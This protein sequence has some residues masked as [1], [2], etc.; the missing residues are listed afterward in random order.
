MGT[1][2]ILRKFL[3]F[4][5]RIWRDKLVFISMLCPLPEHP[6][7]PK[8]IRKKDTCLILANGPSA[9]SI[10]Q[11]LIAKREQ[12]DLYTM[13]YAQQSDVFF[14]LQPVMHI[15]ADPNFFESN[16]HPNIKDA[17]NKLAEV[18]Q[19]TTHGLQ[20]AVP[21]KYFKLAQNIYDSSS[22]VLTSFPDRSVSTQKVWN[23]QL[24]QKG[25]YSFG[26]Q[27]VPS[28]ALYMALMAGYKKILLAGVDADWLKSMSVDQHNKVYWF[29]KHY[30][31]D[32]AKK[33]YSNSSY[34]QEI[35]SIFG[36]FSELQEIYNYANSI[37]VKI[38]NL[39]P[40]S[41]VDIFPKQTLDQ[42]VL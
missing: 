20:I 28:A 4:P 41:M 30:Y 35:S 13:N 37:N 32:S 8:P 25:Y 24:V 42:I 10:L 3:S 19:N 38:I 23:K 7:C 15:L 5:A 29:D 6:Q 2:Q 22:V 36:Y 9:K 1:K 26:A 31:D 27:S 21:L 39:N 16:V 12:F 14:Q 17:R 40:Q 18:L 33:C 11:E 34:S